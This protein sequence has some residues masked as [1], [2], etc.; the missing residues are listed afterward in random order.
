MKQR[1]QTEQAPRAIGPY[2]QAIQSGKTIYF[3]GQIP[4]NPTTMALV[5]DDFREQVQQT[6]ANLVAVTQATGGTLANI[7]KLTIYLVDLAQFS[8]VNEL[9]EKTFS[10]PYPART[11]IQVNALPKQAQIEIEAIMVLD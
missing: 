7:V 4:L 1:I 9:M 2:S 10:E 3:S 5:S 11:T 8:V 6:L